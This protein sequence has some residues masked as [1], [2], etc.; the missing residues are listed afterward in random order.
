MCYT[1]TFSLL[2]CTHNSHKIWYVL[3]PW[4]RI[5]VCQYHLEEFVNS[6]SAYISSK[7]ENSGTITLKWLIYS[8]DVNKCDSS[9]YISSK[10]TKV[11]PNYV[12][13]IMIKHNINNL[14]SYRN[15]GVVY[16]YIYIYTTHSTM[17]YTQN[18]FQ[19]IVPSFIVIYY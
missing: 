9:L 3:S 8:D 7:M 12:F 6:L 1:T 18:K 11:C 14:L 17:F 4:I 5:S 10:K 2:F 19:F 15:S 13:V 16:I